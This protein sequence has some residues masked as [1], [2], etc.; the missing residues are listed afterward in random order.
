MTTFIIILLL[1]AILC[2]V[3]PLAR[4]I[5]RGVAA[6]I[7]LVILIGI[8]APADRPAA[9]RPSPTL[10][11]TDQKKW[12]DFGDRLDEVFSDRGGA[13]ALHREYQ[14]IN[15]QLPMYLGGIGLQSCSDEI[16]MGY[17]TTQ[18]D[19]RQRHPTLTEQD[20]E[21]LDQQFP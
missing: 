8:F 15:R 7:V 2:A 18:P 13:R 12:D 5:G 1:I 17:P 19:D 14:E 3:S 9:D 4:G 11:A 16:L 6:L 21:L 20:H 10:S